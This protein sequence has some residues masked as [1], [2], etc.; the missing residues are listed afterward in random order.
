MPVEMPEPN[1]RS[2][3]EVQDQNSCEF[4]VQIVT[5]IVECKAQAALDELP[6][7]V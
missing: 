6:A 3:Q 1:L 2:N 5:Y 7:K 4:I